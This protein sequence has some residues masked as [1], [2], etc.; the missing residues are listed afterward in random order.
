MLGFMT[1]VAVSLAAVANVIPHFGGTSAPPYMVLVGLR[2]GI[3]SFGAAIGMLISGGAWRKP[4]RGVFVGGLLGAGLVYA[5]PWISSQVLWVQTIP[6]LRQLA[7]V[8]TVAFLCGWSAH[9]LWAARPFFSSR[10]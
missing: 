8:A 6:R 5:L 10:D 2:V 7:L 1:L 3:A 9:W 4:W